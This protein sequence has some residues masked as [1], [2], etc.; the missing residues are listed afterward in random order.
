MS[1]PFQN[2]FKTFEEDDLP[3]ASKKGYEAEVE[4]DQNKRRPPLIG[5]SR[6]PAQGDH[7]SQKKVQKEYRPKT[8]GTSTRQV[9]EI[10]AE[11]EGQDNVVEAQPSR[12]YKDK[13]PAAK[14]ITS[15]KAYSQQEQRYRPK[16]SNLPEEE[17]SH[18][19]ETEESAHPRSNRVVKET[20]FDETTGQKE[21]GEARPK[22]D[23]P[24]RR[25]GAQ[26]QY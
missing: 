14:K 16:G 25:G 11:H 26:E 5:S 12:S 13:A 3:A 23:Y 22:K 9:T 2:Q 4:G 18:K 10:K 7:Y 6:F 17:G 24:K 1:T 19:A 21:E 8:E 20:P 15:G